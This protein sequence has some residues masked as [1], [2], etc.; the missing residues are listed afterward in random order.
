ME[1][2][3]E[4]IHMHRKYNII[5]DYFLRTSN[6]ILDLDIDK[7]F[8]DPYIYNNILYITLPTNDWI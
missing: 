3:F 2:D 1:Y 7:L 4:V 8:L 5:T 6:L